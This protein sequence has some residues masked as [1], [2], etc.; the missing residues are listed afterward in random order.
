MS[1]DYSG[2]VIAVD[3]GQSDKVHI[4][5]WNV[6]NSYM[7]N[8]S[9]GSKEEQWPAGSCDLDLPCLRIQSP[10]PP[11]T[12]TLFMAR[13]QPHWVHK[14]PDNLALERLHLTTF[15]DKLAVNVTT[16]KAW[17]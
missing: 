3:N 4:D 1:L 13:T 9:L 7:V 2:N 15:C 6:I 11:G 10:Q 14:L 5:R 17:C 16:W 12:V 8:V